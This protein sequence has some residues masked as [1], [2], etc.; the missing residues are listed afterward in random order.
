MLNKMVG[1]AATI[2]PSSKV[3]LARLPPCRRSLIPHIKRANYRAAQWEHTHENFPEIQ[4]PAVDPDWAVDD[5]SSQLEPVWS[6]GP[7]LPP[8]MA[9]L[10]SLESGR[11]DEDDVVDMSSDNDSSGAGSSDDDY[12]L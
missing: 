4:F 5:D 3:D 2:T 11:D 8:S 12:D 6:N 1:D 9:D 10:A 7:V